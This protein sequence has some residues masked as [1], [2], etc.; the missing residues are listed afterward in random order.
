M[1][2]ANVENAVLHMHSF[3]LPACACC[4]NQS[5]GWANER[6]QLSYRNWAVWQSAAVWLLCRQAG[7]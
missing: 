5:L 6:R 4:T 7:R 1:A 2:A 3:A